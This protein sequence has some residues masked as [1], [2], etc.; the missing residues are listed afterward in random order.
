MKAKKLTGIFMS[1]SLVAALLAG[2]NSSNAGSKASDELLIG[3]NLELTGGVASY[4]Q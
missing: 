1:L 2:C 3:A 4:G